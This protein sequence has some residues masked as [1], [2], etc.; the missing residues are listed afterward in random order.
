MPDPIFGTAADPRVADQSRARTIRGKAG[1]HQR[2][3]GDAAETLPVIAPFTITNNDPMPVELLHDG[4]GIYGIGVS[5]PFDFEAVAW[6]CGIMPKPDSFQRAPAL[7]LRPDRFMDTKP[8]KAVLQKIVGGFRRGPFMR[9]NEEQ[10]RKI[11]HHAALNRAGLPSPP[12]DPNEKWWSTDKKLQ[13]RNRGVYHGL[14][15]LSLHVINELI[16]KALQEAADAD[17]VRAARRFTF[18]HREGIYRAAALSRRALQLAETFPVLAMAIYSDHWRH[19]RDALRIEIADRKSTAAHLV[20]RGARLR[21]VAAAMNIPMALRHIKPGTAHLATDVFRQHPKILNFLPD[22]T[23]R[24]RIWLLSV[25]WVFR[26]V[27]ADFGAWT[28]RHVSELPGRT[29]QEVGS[30][31]SDI[32]D[33]VSA[34]KPELAFVRAMDGYRGPPPAGQEFVVRPFT[35]SMSFKTV[36]AL[37]AEWHEAVATAMDGPDAAF[38]PPWYP[39]AKVGD[40]DFLPIEKSAELYREGAAMHHCIGTYVDAVQTGRYY[41]Y[42]VRQGDERI[43]TFALVRRAA[44]AE[45]SEIR[46]PCNALVPEKIVAAVRRWL[47][48]QPPLPLRSNR[49]LVD[50]PRTVATPAPDHGSERKR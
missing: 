11:I 14:R 13:A 16:G 41:V 20:D 12:S 3:A 46:G 29:D 38:P 25:N 4:R 31:I 28:A 8:H 18:A 35:S 37:S 15:C 36:T 42:S 19:N 47:C 22:T 49:L 21:D 10:L 43:A 30:L 39:A 2:I 34:G 1:E 50:G 17:A 44:S 26:R 32:A 33:W 48:A 9:S 24:Q 27:D 5:E 7:I 45:L 23:W 6:R 40:L